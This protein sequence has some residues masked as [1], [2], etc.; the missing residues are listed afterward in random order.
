MTTNGRQ[1]RWAEV[2]SEYY[3]MIIYRAGKQNSKAD[4][5]TRRDNEVEAQDSVKAE[6]CTK[7]FPI[8][9]P[10]RPT[11]ALGPWDRGQCNGFLTTN[12]RRRAR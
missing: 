5:L 4:T 12:S 9:R 10:N 3:F 6:Y 7:A 8:L 2:L 1:A 11:S